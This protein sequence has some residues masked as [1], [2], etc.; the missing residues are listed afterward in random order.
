MSLPDF[1]IR[2]PVTT[3]MFYVGVVLFGMISV[4]RLS[5]DLFPPIQ[6]PKLTIVSRYE[7][8]APEEIE[9]L[10]TKPIEEAVGGISGLRKISS[11]SREGLSLVVTEFGWNQKMDFASLAIREKLDL[12]KE[13]LPRDAAE[14]IVIKFN[15]FEQPVMQ[16]SI[17]SRDRSPVQIRELARK[18]FKDEIEKIHGVASA[19]ISGGAEEQILVDVDQSKLRAAGISI[20]E[21]SDAI[22]AANLNFPGGTIKESFY[23]YLV[24]TLGEFKHV[25]EIGGIPV[26]SEDIKEKDRR[27]RQL[28]RTLGRKSLE[29]EILKNVV[30]E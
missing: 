4:Q 20:T 1:S 28:E 6:Y 7:N 12:I 17:S 29:I 22:A 24:R 26:K 16:V 23:E 18:W 19:S 9:T 15:P 8:A 11:T 3:L 5:Q 21:V 30:G 13:R 27:I 14:P 25:S 10:I 2:R